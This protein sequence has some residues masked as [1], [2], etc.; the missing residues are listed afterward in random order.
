LLPLAA[1]LLPL[2]AATPCCC[3]A[4]LPATALRARV[5]RARPIRLLPSVD[6]LPALQRNPDLASSAMCNRRLSLW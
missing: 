1:A 6:L 2:A 3:H 5:V 4:L